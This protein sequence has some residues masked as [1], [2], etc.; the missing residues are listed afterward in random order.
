LLACVELSTAAANIG[1]YLCSRYI[2]RVHI[3]KYN[4]TSLAYNYKVHVLVYS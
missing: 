4:T 1:M 2:S 3:Y